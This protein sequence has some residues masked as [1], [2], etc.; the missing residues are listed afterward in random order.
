M[1]GR[2][3]YL[4]PGL[5]N[6]HVHL[7]SDGKP[8]PELLTGPTFQHVVSAV[9]HSPAGTMLS[10]HRARVNARSL[11]LS[12]VTTFRTVGDV[13]YEAVALQRKFDSGKELGAR[14]LASGPLLAITGGHGGPQI[15]MFSDSPW[16][17]RRNTRINI[18]NG[19]SA[20][21]IA[22]TGGVTDA[23]RIGDAGRPQ[24]SEEE[25]AAV[26][27]EAHHAGLLVAAHAQ[28]AEGVTMALRAGVDTIEHGCAMNAEIIDLFHDNPLSL[29]GWSALIPTLSAAL[30]LVLLSQDITG[31]SDIV[32]ANAR[33]A[34]DEMIQGIHDA[35]AH[36]IAIGLGTDTAMTYVTQYNTWRELALLNRFGGLTPL[37]AI[38]AATRENARILGLDDVTGKIAKGF[39]ADLL[40]LR[41]NPL[42]DWESFAHPELVATRGKVLLHPRVKRFDDIDSE[43]DSMQG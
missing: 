9:L 22:A 35:K 6:A 34:V 36:G 13:G 18:M 43:L 20:I 42:R 24:M 39:S 27:V 26:C 31:V 8:L 32:V 14:M 3:K 15:A 38:R 33:L 17:A 21:K 28:S 25:M 12:G 11:L 5:I 19:V 7:F 16:Q 37:Q 41:E 4:L 2:G 23:R 40:L 1:D 10:R 30:P 29:R